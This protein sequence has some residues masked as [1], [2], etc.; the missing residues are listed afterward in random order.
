MRRSLELRNLLRRTLC[1][2][3]STFGACLGAAFALCAWR[4]RDA[5][6][7]PRAAMAVPVSALPAVVA[8]LMAIA[9]PPQIHSRLPHT[10][11]GAFLLTL[12]LYWPSLRW[13]TAITATY[14][15]FAI[16]LQRNRPEYSATGMWI[17]II[18][19]TALVAMLVARH[20]RV[21]PMFLLLV[22]SSTSMAL[23]K[24]FLPPW[25]QR[26]QVATQLVFVLLAVISAF[27]LRQRRLHNEAEGRS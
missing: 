5:L 23:L 15:A 27:V 17:F 21:R 6:S 22:A 16:D 1:D 4:N 19:S 14:C 2:D 3:A 7:A 10:V 12:V 8:I 24:Q 18:V 20:P 25:P 11:A 13:H 26:Q 9:L